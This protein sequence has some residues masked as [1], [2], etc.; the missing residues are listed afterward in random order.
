[1]K[2]ITRR[3]AS[4]AAAE[5][6]QNRLYDQYDC[7]RLVRFPMFEESGIYAWEVNI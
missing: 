1:M 3:F 6:F 7:V 2:T 4:L 5:R